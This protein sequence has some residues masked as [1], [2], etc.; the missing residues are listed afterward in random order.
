MY[1]N[2]TQ[3]IS[4]KLSEAN[5]IWNIRTLNN[6]EYVSEHAINVMS[7]L[8]VLNYNSCNFLKKMYTWVWFMWFG[9][10]YI[11]FWNEYFK[12]P[13][14]CNKMSLTLC[15][16]GKN[17]LSVWFF[18]ALNRGRAVT[19]FTPQDYSSISIVYIC[20]SFNIYIL[21]SQKLRMISTIN[22]LRQK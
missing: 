4:K 20:F 9:F 16:D 12:R 2:F 22:K 18:L 21:P 3:S 13:T 19:R 6:N 11:F 7:F 10:I 1:S 15:V 14:Y 8:C 17:V 5:F